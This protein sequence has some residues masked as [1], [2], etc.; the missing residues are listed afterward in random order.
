MKATLFNS[1]LLYINESCNLET[2]DLHNTYIS[3]RIDKNI[4]RNFLNIKNLNIDN[5][6]IIDICKFSRY[7]SSHVDIK[8]DVSKFIQSS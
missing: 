6:Y 5:S 8:I 4:L 2:L 7:H 1:S 3:D